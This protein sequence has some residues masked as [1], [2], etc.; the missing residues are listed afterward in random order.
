MDRK[1]KKINNSRSC[2]YCKHIICLKFAYFSRAIVPLKKKS[3]LSCSIFQFKVPSLKCIGRILRMQFS[4]PQNIKI[5]QAFLN[6]FLQHLYEI[7]GNKVFPFIH[8]VLRSR[9][10]FLPAP[11]PAPIKSRHSIIRK[12]FY[13][14]PICLTRKSLFILSIKF[15]INLVSMLGRTERI[16]LRNSKVETEPD[17]HTGSDQ[18]LPAPE[19]CIHPSV[20]Q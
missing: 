15:L 2:W 18:K 1:N 12:F 20:I 14:I 4:I 9:S 8:P 6:L 10:V 3:P 11:A 16:S 13:T 17:L 19:H 5:V 7:L